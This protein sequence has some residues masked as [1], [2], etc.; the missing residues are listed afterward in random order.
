MTLN[1]NISALAIAVGDALQDLDERIVKSGVFTDKVEDDSFLTYTPDQAWSVSAGDTI[2]DTRG[3]W[4][5]A[6]SGA[7]DHHTVTAGGVKLYEAG[8][9]F[10][11]LAHAESAWARAVVAGKTF[12][13]GTVWTWPDQAIRFTGTGYFSPAF[14]GWESEG[15]GSITSEDLNN[16]G[17]VT[18]SDVDALGY[19]T[20][21][22]FNDFAS[23][24]S[25]DQGVS[26]GDSPTFVSV[27]T[28]SL[29]GGDI[30]AR[31]LELSGTEAQL[32]VN[33]TQVAGNLPYINISGVATTQVPVNSVFVRQESATRE[34]A[35]TVHIQRYTTTNGGFTNPHALS[36]LYRVNQGGDTTAKPWAISGVMESNTDSIGSGGEAG[37]AVS[38]VARKMVQNAGVMFGGH[39]QVK[40]ET[41]APTQGGIIGAE[42]NIQA[43]GPDTNQNRVG[44]DIIARTFSGGV[45]GNGRFTAGIRVRNNAVSPGGQWNVGV[46]VE[47]GLERVPVAFKSS[48][49][50]T[51]TDGYGLFDEGVKLYGVRASGSYGRAAFATS[52]GQRIELGVVDGLP[53]TMMYSGANDRIEFY[54]GTLLRGFID[55][56][57]AGSGGSMN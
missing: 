55:M 31:Q 53:I 36:V 34:E 16:S 30:T 26:T 47:D 22:D 6:A 39:L 28:G 4:E 46:L 3:T 13:I 24:V 29:G 20:S 21:G 41:D 15:F 54:K 17:F 57:S 48:N 14:P 12:S 44:L 56:T 50:T 37:T 40:D 43:N 9:N 11:S 19:V 1:E 7:A 5:V 32:K 18:A 27:N 33:P 51:L 45:S 49:G 42:I 2:T 38:G 35:K 25:M 52:T 23:T 8:R 10:S